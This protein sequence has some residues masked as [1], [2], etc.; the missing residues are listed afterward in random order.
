M[1]LS[2]VFRPSDKEIDQGRSF[3]QGELHHGYCCQVRF[4]YRPHEDTQWMSNTG[5]H[6][7]Q[8]VFSGHVL[9][10]CKLSPIGDLSRFM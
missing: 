8:N 4:V 9:E 3:V 6:L 7:T 2:L 10:P 1:T 5:F